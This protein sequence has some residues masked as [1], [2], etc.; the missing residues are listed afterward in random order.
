MKKRAIGSDLPAI[1]DHPHAR[2]RE[3]KPSALAKH[4]ITA[5]L[6][7]VN[8]HTGEVYEPTSFI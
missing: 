8:T 7:S 4:N 6:L 5:R 2:D 3:I 1:T